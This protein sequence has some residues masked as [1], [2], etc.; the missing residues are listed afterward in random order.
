VARVSWGQDRIAADSREREI[1]A[2]VTARRTHRGGFGP[3]PLSAGTISALRTEAA[4]EGAILRLVAA[5]DQRD[6]LA[7]AVQAGEHALG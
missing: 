6:A 5:G 7:A 1:Y 2:A 3:A 4:R